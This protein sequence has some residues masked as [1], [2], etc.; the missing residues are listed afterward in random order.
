M[1]EGEVIYFLDRFHPLLVIFPL[2]FLVLQ[3]LIGLNKCV[4][5]VRLVLHL[6]GVLLSHL[7]PLKLKQVLLVF[8]LLELFVQVSVLLFMDLI[9]DPAKQIIVVGAIELDLLSEAVS[10]FTVNKAGKERVGDSIWVHNL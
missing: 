2:I 8:P 4:R 7:R 9:D 5:L 10:H 3:D 6:K 1:S